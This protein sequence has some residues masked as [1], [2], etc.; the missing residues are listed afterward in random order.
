MWNLLA[1]AILRYKKSILIVLFIWAIGAVYL[2]KDVKITYHFGR[3]I[4][5][6]NPKYL[7]LQEFK[8]IFGEDGKSVF[9][10]IEQADFLTKSNINAWYR[11]AE[12]MKKIDGVESVVD[13]AHAFE[14]TKDT[15]NKRLVPT[16]LMAAELAD[17]AST[18][19]FINKAKLLPFYTNLLINEKGNATL[20]VVSIK[21]ELL[22]TK[23]RQRV[24]NTIRNE[25]SSYEKAANI[26]THSSGLPLARSELM[27][28]LRH[29]MLM[30]ALM[31][32]LVSVVVLFLF[33]RSF[34]II[35]I[36]MVVVLFGIINTLASMVV[37][38][39]EV[40]ILS[41]LIPS[42]MVVI[43]IPNVIYLVNKY[44]Q[45]YL[46]TNN[47]NEALHDS[48][49]SIGIVTLFTNLTA[50]AGFAVFALTNA[51]LLKEFGVVSG[52]NIM[53]LFV[54]S[55]LLIPILLSYFKTNIEAETKYLH[56]TWVNGIKQW[57]INVALHRTRFIYTLSGLIVVFSAIGLWQLNT[58]SY[59]LD[60]IPQDGKMYKD[61]K[62]F[63]NNFGGVMPFEVLIDCKKAGR[64][65]QP[66]VFDKIEQLSLIMQNAAVFSKPMS[67]A[68]GLKF[69]TQTY[70]DGDT[71]AYRLPQ[72]GI[73]QAFVYSYLGKD[74]VRTPSSRLLSTFIDSSKRYL[75]VTAPMS[76]I[77]SDSLGRVLER[78]SPQVSSIFDTSKYKV[79]LTGT[80]VTFLEGN[81]FII[82]SMRDSILYAFLSI[83]VCM[84]ILF[85][86][87]RI[88]FI[89]LLP[90][91][92]PLLFIAGVL[93]VFRIPI[94]PST[95]LVFS[96]ALGISIDI[97]IRFL[98]F[99]AKEKKNINQLQPV[100]NTIHE[101][102]VSIIYTSIILCAGF[103]IYVFSN[104]GGTAVLGWLTASALLLSTISNLVLLPMLLDRW[105][106]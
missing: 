15:I 35:L 22:D 21:K 86:R 2:A 84:L 47:K 31:S 20:M 99:Y 16:A 70:Y 94:K 43:G 53:L 101:A 59:I 42:L 10:G 93:G 28:L 79:T 38:G 37:L 75:R 33:F 57:I 25:I 7:Q 74:T 62:W 78:L 5:T 9:I 27:E 17:E 58:N 44:H 13:I 91:I 19:T 105:D 46:K 29:E 60:D 8:K 97:T 92:L 55:I 24:I 50:A 1:I 36:A 98:V 87:I 4:P 65:K 102:T 41:G 66:V 45:T 68:E 85:K 61:L 96:I 34:N 30:F 51:V 48:I 73:E 83:L 52:I 103:F 90:N 63:E 88:V 95:V 100:I 11:L 12:A 104:F 69:V 89:A 71:S 77:G 67:I 64:A 26:T 81:K 82:R 40:T 80:S 56:W 23:E 76:D 6:D 54:F 39:Y 49:R 32:I 18:Q 72:G 3:T 14:L 106:K